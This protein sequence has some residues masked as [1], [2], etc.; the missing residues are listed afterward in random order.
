MG[1]LRDRVEAEQAESEQD[2]TEGNIHEV[3]DAVYNLVEPLAKFVTA[4]E[5]HC[6]DETDTR[7]QNRIC[8]EN[9]A[10]S[11]LRFVAVG[12]DVGIRSQMDHF[13]LFEYLLK[14]ERIGHDDQKARGRD[15]LE[16]E[17]TGAHLFVCFRIVNLLFARF[18]VGE[19]MVGGCGA[20]FQYFN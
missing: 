15:Q 1:Q 10:H 16:R 7:G 20:F 4:H 3:C 5:R 18:L 6:Q 12:V 14:Y 2:G 9:N 13:K 11:D 8:R 17:I 19:L